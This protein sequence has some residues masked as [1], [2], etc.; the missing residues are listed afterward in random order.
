MGYI[1]YFLSIMQEA[2]SKVVIKVDLV[3]GMFTAITILPQ[4]EDTKQVV[5][6][7]AKIIIIVLLL[8]CVV[9]IRQYYEMR[10]LLTPA[11]PNSILYSV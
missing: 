6:L 1:S 11:A 4:T 7:G 9:Q 10:M 8:F 2:P 3:K 5:P